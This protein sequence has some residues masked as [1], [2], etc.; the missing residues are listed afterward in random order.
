[1]KRVRA[2]GIPLIG[3]T[4]WPLFALVTWGY[5]EGRKE[6]Q[7]YLKQ[8]GLWD[9]VPRGQT[10]ERVPTELVDEFRELVA[11]GAERVGPLQ[12]ESRS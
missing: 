8:M 10:L 2:K 11:R 9:L 1:V 6:P 4:W 5:R 7:E 12:R 3:Y